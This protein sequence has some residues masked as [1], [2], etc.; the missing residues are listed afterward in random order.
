[1]VALASLLCRWIDPAAR[2]CQARFVDS[3]RIVAPFTD[4]LPDLDQ[5]F[6]WRPSPTIRREMSSTD[7][8]RP[9]HC[10]SI[11]ELVYLTVFIPDDWTDA[12]G[13]FIW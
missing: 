13:N 10:T 8:I 3:C 2:G 4:M 9:F 5:P 11:G 6:R 1:M 12:H 7:F